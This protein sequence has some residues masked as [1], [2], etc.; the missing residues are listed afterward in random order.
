MYCDGGAN[1]IGPQLYGSKAERGGKKL[2]KG[3]DA[4]FPECRSCISGG[5][6]PI[7]EVFEAHDA[8]LRSLPPEEEKGKAERIGTSRGQIIL[9]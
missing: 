8:T 4:V 7:Q 3:K 6:S 2:G 1:R 9:G 5:E